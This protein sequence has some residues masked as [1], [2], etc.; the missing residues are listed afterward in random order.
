MVFKNLICGGILLGDSEDNSEP[1]SIPESMRKSVNIHDKRLKTMK[2]NPKF[3]E[4]LKVI[5][6]CHEIYA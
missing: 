6:L 4:A 3:L 1:S 2:T 5:Y